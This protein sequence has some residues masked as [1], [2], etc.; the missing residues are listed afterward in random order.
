MEMTGKIT[1]HQ[2]LRL[3]YSDQLSSIERIFRDDSWDT[4]ELREAVGRLLIGAYDPGIYTNQLKLRELNK[5]LQEIRSSL[6]SLYLLLSGYEHSLTLT[7]VEAEKSKLRNEL[8]SL[9]EQISQLEKLGDSE[10][11]SDFTLDPQRE[12]FETLQ[13]IQQ[14]L[15]KARDHQR[16]LEL[17]YA[18]SELFIT[19]IKNKIDH[20]RDANNVSSLVSELKYVRCPSCHEPI[21]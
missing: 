2:I 7:W 20:L 21:Q 5:E 8:K 14:G 11:A 15:G 3:I 16:M 1:L 6:R 18:D 9:Q 13:K 17:E 12:A 19:T 4:P 10:Q